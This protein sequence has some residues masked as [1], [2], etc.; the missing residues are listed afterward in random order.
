MSSV[1]SYVMASVWLFDGMDMSRVQITEYAKLCEIEPIM[2]VQ[3][4]KLAPALDVFYTG[5]QSIS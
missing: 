3:Q 2:K 5:Y 1:L 4:L